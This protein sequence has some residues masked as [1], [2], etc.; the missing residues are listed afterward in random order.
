MRTN[1]LFYEEDGG[2]KMGL[3]FGTELVVRLAPVFLDLIRERKYE[4]DCLYGLWNERQHLCG[5]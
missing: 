3:A 5:V 1:G 4:E 2:V